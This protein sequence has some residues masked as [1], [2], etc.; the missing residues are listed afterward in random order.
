MKNVFSKEAK[1]GIITIVSLILLYAGV[2]YLKGINLF[3]PTNHYFVSFTNVKDVT[4]SSPVYVDG[5]KV[6]LV[7]DMTFD[8]ET[9]NKITIEISLEDKMRINR[10]SYITVV[11]SLLGGAELH[12]ELNTHLESFYNPGDE[13]EGRMTVDMMSK[14]ENSILP[15]VVNLLPKIDSILG[16]IQTL[17]NHPAL[18]ASLNNIQNTTA[19]LEKSTVKLNSLLANDVPMIVNSLKTIT[20]DFSEVSGTLKGLDINNTFQ[21]IQATINNL[22]LTTEKLNSTDNTIGLLLNDKQLY[23]NLNQ[24]AINASEL[25]FDLKKNPKRYVHF[26]VF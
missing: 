21:S 18:S 20:S 11:K 17:I 24:T 16:G 22:Q 13:I 4:I 2:N 5:F 1:I 15:E 14:I 12:I 6:G 19:N 25:M 23:D 26:S 8:Y 9:N 3:Q 7:R 10:G